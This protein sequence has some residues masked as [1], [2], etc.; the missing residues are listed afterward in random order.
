MMHLNE[1]FF[2]LNSCTNQF[3]GGNLNAFGECQVLNSQVASQILYSAPLGD[4]ARVL[5]CDNLK[6]KDTLVN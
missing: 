5:G 1:F 6:Q 4:Y 3:P 2:F